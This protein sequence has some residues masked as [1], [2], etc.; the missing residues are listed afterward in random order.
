MHS[1]HEAVFLFF[2]FGH[3]FGLKF[4]DSIVPVSLLSRMSGFAKK[5]GAEIKL[6]TSILVQKIFFSECGFSVC[7]M[8][9]AVQFPTSHLSANI[10]GF[11]LKY[12]I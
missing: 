3:F 5:S 8:A 6:A 4:G 11:E 12:A 7:R 9:E 1:H 10:M 2:I